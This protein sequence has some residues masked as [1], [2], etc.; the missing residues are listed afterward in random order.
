MPELFLFMAVYL[1]R[2][3]PYCGNYFGVVIAKRNGSGYRPIHGRCS[4]CGYEV[5]WALISA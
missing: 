2:D 4:V 5:A 1:A 3:C